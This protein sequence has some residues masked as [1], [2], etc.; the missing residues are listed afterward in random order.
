V[1]RSQD[2]LSRRRSS[3]AR[4]ADCGDAFRDPTP[5]TSFLSSRLLHGWG[6]L[7][8]LMQPATVDDPTKLITTRIVGGRHH[9]HTL[10]AA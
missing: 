2:G 3:E 1:R 4:R 7:A 5:L 6:D 9:T 10:V 8:Q